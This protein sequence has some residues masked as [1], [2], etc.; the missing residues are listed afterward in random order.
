MDDG[1][2]EHSLEDQHRLT[3]MVDLVS[4]LVVWLASPEARFMKCKFMWA[5]FDVDEMKERATEIEQ[6][7]DLPL[8]LL[9][10]TLPAKIYYCKSKRNWINGQVPV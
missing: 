5:N 8:G 9:G 6:G 1:K 3:W 2:L 10:L 7:P 4:G